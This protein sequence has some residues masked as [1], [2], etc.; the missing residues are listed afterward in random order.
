MKY[1]WL[2]KGLSMLLS[3]PHCDHNKKWADH[4][5]MTCYVDKINFYFVKL[6]LP[7]V[8]TLCL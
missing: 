8:E 3:S 6:V 5:Q 1:G 7:D 2:G 4:N